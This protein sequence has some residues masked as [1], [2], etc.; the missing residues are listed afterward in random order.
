M[1]THSQDDPSVPGPQP[2][3]PARL[4]PSTTQIESDHCEDRAAACERTAQRLRDPVARDIFARAARRWRSTANESDA[5]L[6]HLVSW[7]A[8]PPVAG[9]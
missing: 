1:S 4:R 7:L 8:P 6:A 9:E 5:R 2:R 3:E